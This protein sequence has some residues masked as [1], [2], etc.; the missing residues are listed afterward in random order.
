MV[1]AGLALN[2]V[3]V[4]AIKKTALELAV[5]GKGVNACPRHD[6]MVEHAHI[7]QAQG[8]HQRPH[9]QQVRFASFPLTALAAGLSLYNCPAPRQIRN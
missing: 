3:A 2:F 4:R 6:E 9:E 7:D 1:L 8:L 5:L